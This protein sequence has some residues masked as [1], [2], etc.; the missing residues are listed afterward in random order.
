MES[1]CIRAAVPADIPLLGPIE[2]AAD[3][4]FIEAGHPEFSGVISDSDAATGV[5][6]GRI[7]VAE[8]RGTVLGWVHVG[9][10]AGELCVEQISVHPDHQ[11]RGI[12]SLL[13]RHVMAQARDANEDSIILDTQSDVPWNR[14]WYERLGFEVVP[15]EEWTLEMTNVATRQA[16]GGMD[17]GTRVFMR[18][19]S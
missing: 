19:R 2:A 7:T 9:R 12:G 13:M 1:P 3:L 11:R 8:D 18:W 17:W 6:E 10:L 14:P 15:P 5:A 16:A 4:L